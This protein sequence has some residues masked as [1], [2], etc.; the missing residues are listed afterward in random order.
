MRHIKIK[1]FLALLLLAVLLVYLFSCATVQTTHVTR[2]E[3]TLASL[4]QHPLPEWYDDAKLG[5]MIHYGIY[6]VDALAWAPLA[7]PSGFSGDFFTNNPYVAWNYNTINIAGSPFQLYS[8]SNYGTT[9]YL[10]YID[11]FNLQSQLWDPQ[12]WINTIKSAGAKYAVLVTKHHDGFVLWPSAHTNPYFSNY[13]SQ[14]DIV[15]DFVSALRAD[16]TLK[17]GLYYS[18]GYDWMW[19][20]G[21]T[22][23]GPVTDSRITTPITNNIVGIAKIPQDSGFIAYCGN[24]YQELISNYSPDLLWNDIAMPLGFPKLELF[25]SYYNSFEASAGA[26]GVVV[27]NRWAQDLLN[28]LESF[29]PSQDES[30]IDLLLTDDWFDYYNM[31][32]PVGGQ[33]QYTAKKW[34]ADRAIGY[35]FAYN[36]QE[37]ADQTHALS[38]EALV[39]LL[40]DIVSKN[41]NLLLGVG[42]MANGT[43]PTWQVVRLQAMGN[44][45]SKNGDAIYATRPW[46]TAEGQ[47]GAG[48][49]AKIETRYTRS[50]DNGRL[51]VVLMENP[52]AQDVTLTDSQFLSPN[53]ATTITVLNGSS[54]LSARWETTSGGLLVRL[55]LVENLPQ[56]SFPLVLRINPIPTN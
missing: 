46:V 3:A 30:F 28:L 48:S 25:A 5:I 19:T 31:E 43:I 51:Y 15:G 8:L 50:K 9:E 45:L 27:N 11:T 16:G 33:Y 35:A 13:H 12:E 10:S 49:G 55:S 37:V 56:D 1:L 44:W 36:K 38:G 54:P 26:A 47:A 7:D 21:Q 2:Y 23:G 24:H 22:R 39:R 18:G 29:Y 17:L 6:S 4:K 52:Q 40:A 53:P 41:G 42:P 14:R 34:E 32:Y 20:E